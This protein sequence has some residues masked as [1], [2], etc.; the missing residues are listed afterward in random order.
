MKYVLSFLL[1]AGLIGLSAYELIQ[2]VRV[3][4]EKRKQKLEKKKLEI[5]EKGDDKE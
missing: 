1:I 4:K 5:N 3:F 2:L